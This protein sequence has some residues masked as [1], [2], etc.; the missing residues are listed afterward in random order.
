[1]LL[2]ASPA[3]ALDRTWLP[4]DVYET[5]QAQ[6]RSEQ[7]L[8]LVI[9]NAGYEGENRL[10]NPYNDARAMAVALDSLGFAVDIRRDLR[11]KAEFEAAIERLASRLQA[12][13]GGVVFL[14]YSGHGLHFGEENWL[15][16]TGAR[17]RSGAD[18]KYQAVTVDFVIRA[19]HDA[20]ARM[21]VLA[22]DACRTNNFAIGVRGA[23]GM[24]KRP[25]DAGPVIN[26]LAGAPSWAPRGIVVAYAAS[27]GQRA[28]DGPPG[29]QSPW[30]QA[31]TRVLRKPGLELEDILKRA[32]DQVAQQ[33]H[34]QQT[35]TES[36]SLVGELVFKSLPTDVRDIWAAVLTRSRAE[37][38]A[39]VIEFIE[40][41]ASTGAPEL[42]EAAQWLARDATE[43][44]RTGGEAW[45]SPSGVR[46][47]WVPA[48]SADDGAP[49][50]TDTVEGGLWFMETEVNQELF[51]SLAPSAGV[52]MQEGTACQER[53]GG[54]G[55]GANLP[56]VCL[57]WC[58]AV[59]LANAL[60][61]RDGLRP[62]YVGSPE[63]DHARCDPFSVV[64]VPDSDGYR[65]PTSDEWAWAAAIDRH[66]DA[67]AG[68]GPRC[69]LGNGPDRSAADRG[70]V[71]TAW[72]CSDGFPGPA[73]V[74]ALAA[75]GWGLHQVVGNAWEWLQD[76]PSD[77]LDGVP[78]QRL[79]RLAA[80]G[81]WASRP[82]DVG[83]DARTHFPPGH[84]SEV[85]GLRL[86]RSAD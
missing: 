3:A 23:P 51:A 34:G 12:S 68:E 86:C 45:V 14:Y 9:G 28:D 78:D 48:P 1:M 38:R 72:D 41:Y 83:V 24:K 44:P 26:R 4:F 50:A 30:N 5:R 47:R 61:A 35:P 18:L 22:L 60:S 42:A 84:R 70:L 10:I 76:G 71:R 32:R 67:G 55:V 2:A 56:A 46:M 52:P 66:G 16:P 79:W 43:T 53:A 73:P 39:A 59:A 7:R 65:L 8:A 40:D 36:S 85:L 21:V 37:R 11:T 82:G 17:L 49:A 20:G 81:S 63:S 54:G 25:V 27:D 69:E 13:P 57:S 77:G 19:L 29:K 15:I 6:A 31:L 64:L 62:A 75:N 58:D 80:G 33:T 74:D